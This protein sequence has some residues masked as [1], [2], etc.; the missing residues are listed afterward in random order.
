MLALCRDDMASLDFVMTG[1]MDKIKTL[2]YTYHLWA[3]GYLRNK[4]KLIVLSA[5]FGVL[6]RA[7]YVYGTYE[8][9]PIIVPRFACCVLSKGL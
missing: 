8:T 7:D 3:G 2:N 1:K 9:N 6:R 5:A 4:A